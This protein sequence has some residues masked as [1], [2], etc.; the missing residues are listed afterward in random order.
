MSAGFF[1]ESFLIDA[2]LC[3]R[4]A[5]LDNFFHVAFGYGH[6]AKGVVVVSEAVKEDCGSFAV[7]ARFVVADIHGI[8]VLLCVSDQVLAA[9]S[10]GR[11]LDVDHLVVVGPVTAPVVIAGDLGV[12][13]FAAG[14][15]KDA[16]GSLQAE[17]AGWCFPISLLDLVDSV[18]AYIGLAVKDLIPLFIFASLV[19]GEG[20]IVTAVV[21]YEN[22]FLDVLVVAVLVEDRLPLAFGRRRFGGGFSRFHGGNHGEDGAKHYCNCNE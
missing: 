15:F 12:A 5:G 8:G 19:E 21:S 9:A 3:S 6:A 2:Y 10:V 1:L 20:G 14:V 7:F 16:E 4:L 11:A 18:L 22:E 17:G 13:H